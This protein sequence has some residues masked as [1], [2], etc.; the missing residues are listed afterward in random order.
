[1]HSA[2]AR[3]QPEGTANGGESSDRESRPARRSTCLA[4][5]RTR[6]AKAATCRRDAEEEDALGQRKEFDA[7]T[8]VT[9]ACTEVAALPTSQMKR[10]EEMMYCLLRAAGEANLYQEREDSAKM[11]GSRMAFVSRGQA[12][13]AHTQ[14]HSRGQRG[15]S[16]SWDLGGAHAR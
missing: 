1:M 13:C 5:L 15:R 3:Q 2:A 14:N 4:M 10:C 11:T 7:S 6:A 12:P 9:R 16:G 8:R